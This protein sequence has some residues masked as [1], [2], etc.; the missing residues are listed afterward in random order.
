MPSKLQIEDG[1]AH[2]VYEL[3]ALRDVAPRP[4]PLT[5]GF[6]EGTLT[7][8]LRVGRAPAFDRARAHRDRAAGVG[9]GPISFLLGGGSP[10]R[11]RRMSWSALSTTNGLTFSGGAAKRSCPARPKLGPL[12]DL[13]EISLQVPGNRSDTM[14]MGVFSWDCGSAGEVSSFE[15]MR[16]ILPPQ[17]PEVRLLLES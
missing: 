14:S 5:L 3:E 12:V 17:R 6:D 11:R 4:P 7:A 10:G 1:V 15:S 9:G 16:L 13:R 8:R 2:Y